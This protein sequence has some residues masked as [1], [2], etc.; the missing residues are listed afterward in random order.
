[1]RDAQTVHGGGMASAVFR[2]VNL[3]VLQRADALRKRVGDVLQAQVT[4]VSFAC[5]DDLNGPRARPADAV[6]PGDC[7]CVAVARVQCSAASNIFFRDMISACGI[8]SS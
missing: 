2:F 3:A 7:R 1:M 6:S 5:S 8:L 4:G